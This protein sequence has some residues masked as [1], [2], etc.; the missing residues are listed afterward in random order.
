MG[1]WIDRLRKRA[2]SFQI[3]IRKPLTEPTKAPSVSNVSGQPIG[4]Q[5]NKRVLR[6][7]STA[8]NREVLVVPDDCDPAVKDW[9][10]NTYL[11]S[12]VRV[13]HRD[14]LSSESVQSVHMVREVFEGI[15]VD[16]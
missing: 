10:P 16:V 15:V 6:V 9:N 5:K 12:E 13:I 1:K 11:D 2:K 3:P 4:I 8:L 7:N 14:K